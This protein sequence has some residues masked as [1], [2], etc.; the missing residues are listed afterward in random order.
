MVADFF[1]HLLPLALIG[2]VSPV[3]LLNAFRVTGSGGARAGARF[4]AGAALV[5][6]VIGVAAMGIMGAAASQELTRALASRVVDV[7]L[8]LLVIGYG[9]WQLRDRRQAEHTA[10][11][12]QTP[13]TTK[14]GGFGAG[15]IGMLTNFTTLPLFLSAAQHLGAQSEPF[16]LKL[17]ILAVLIVV[18]ATPSW[19]PFALSVLKRG[20]TVRIKASTERKVQSVTGAVSI[21]ACLIGGALI[22]VHVALGGHAG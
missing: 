10:R 14:G 19:L 21:G 9:I 3:M 20:R 12:A 18:V 13:A 4:A 17:P 7:V 15:V 5:L 1:G 2:A 22:L 16:A 6:V 8:A 11:E